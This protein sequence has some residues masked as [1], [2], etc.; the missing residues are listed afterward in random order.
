[1]KIQRTNYN[2]LLKNIFS[3]SSQSFTGPWR[4]RSLSL[5]SLLVGYYLCSVISAYF[6][7]ENQ[8]RVIV[9]LLLFILIEIAVR[10]RVFLDRN[11]KKNALLIIDNLRIGSFYAIVLEAFKLGS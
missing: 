5:L 7:V 3:S 2:S 6:L 10:L 8:Q 9:V 4:S 1:M 11:S